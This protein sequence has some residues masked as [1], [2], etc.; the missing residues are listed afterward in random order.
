M[1]QQNL[2]TGWV[3]T[4]PVGP[5]TAPGK[6]SPPMPFIPHSN[7]PSQWVETYTLG[8]PRRR[9]KYKSTA[10]QSK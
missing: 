10:L 5:A 2:I 9:P 4:A 1:L 7:A 3:G 8:A 6:S